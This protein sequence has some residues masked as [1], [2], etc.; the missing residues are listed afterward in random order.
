M[1]TVSVSVSCALSAGYPFAILEAKL[2]EAI[3]AG[4]KIKP[5]HAVTITNLLHSFSDAD[6]DLPETYETLIAY[7]DNED[8]AIR[9]LAYWHLYR[10]VPVGQKIGYNPLAPKEERQQAINQWQKLIPKGK[11]A[12]CHFRARSD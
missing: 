2:Y 8:L 1:V 3:L 6:L 9:G 7:L 5:S 4:K 11:S 10:L 12:S